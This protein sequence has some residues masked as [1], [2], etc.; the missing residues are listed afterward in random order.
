ML[1]RQS[2]LERAQMETTQA[3]AARKPKP[4]KPRPRN[5]A[6]NPGTT[7]DQQQQQQQQ[8]QNQ[9]ITIPDEDGDAEMDDGTDQEDDPN[10]EG[11]DNDSL[12]EEEGPWIAPLIQPIT[13]LKLPHVRPTLLL[14][15]YDCREDSLAAAQDYA[16]K[17]GYVLISIGLGKTKGPEGN[18]NE[19][20][21]MELKCDRGGICKM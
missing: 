16:I 19:V 15:P 7:Q 13:P 12:P 17:Q 9:P 2:A 21:R 3:L 11:D 4:R 5:G 8:N 14:G 18:E 6:Q 1:E 20:T 10:A